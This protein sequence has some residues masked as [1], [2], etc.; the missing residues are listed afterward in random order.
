MFLGNALPV[1]RPPTLVS[2]RPPRQSAQVPWRHC[3]WFPQAF[4]SPLRVVEGALL[5][6]CV[7][8]PSQCPWAL[9]HRISFGCWKVASQRCSLYLFI[10]RGHSLTCILYRALPFNSDTR[11]SRPDRFAGIAPVSVA[12]IRPAEFSDFSAT[13]PRTQCHPQPAQTH[14]CR[15]PVLS[16]LPHH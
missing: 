4:S 12:P 3:C 2:F 7:L 5:H 10:G 14:H 1:H 9:R 16:A 6:T 15:D 13:L 11:A 8:R